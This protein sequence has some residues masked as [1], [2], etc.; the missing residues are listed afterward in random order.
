MTLGVQGITRVK[1]EYN[2]VLGPKKMPCSPIVA[3]V[4]NTTV[5]KYYNSLYTNI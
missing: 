4:L 5:S 2:G 3:R 1:Y